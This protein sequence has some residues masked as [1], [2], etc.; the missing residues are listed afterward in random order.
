MSII[1]IAVKRPVTTVMLTLCLVVTGLVSMGRVPLGLM[2]EMNLP[3]AA[4]ITSYGTASPQEVETLVTKPLESSFASLSNMKNIVSYSS[5]GSSTIIVEFAWGTNM[6]LATLEMR[7]RTDLVKGSLPEGA[8]AP[9]VV[10]FDPSSIPLMQIGLDSRYD[11]VTLRQ[12]ADDVVAPRLERLEGVANVTVEGGLEREIQVAV[13]PIQLDSYNLSLQ[14]VTQ[15]LAAANLNLPGGRVADKTRELAVRTLGEYTDIKEIEELMLPGGVRLKDVAVVQDT[16]KEQTSLTRIN[17]R[18]S[19]GLYIQKESGANT[20]FV[21]SRVRAELERIMRDYDGG[22]GY[23]IFWD[24]SD[25]VV[26]ALRNLGEN[27][28]VGALLAVIVLLIFLKN[29]RTTLVIGTAI[30]VGIISAFILLFFGD[31]SLNMMSLGGLALSVG[32]LVDNGI[33]V[34]ENIF[35]HREEGSLADDAARDGAKEVALAII[36]STLTTV[37]V[38]LPIVF[39]EGIAAQLFADLSKTVTFALLASLLVSL[40]LVPMISAQLMR[41][42]TVRQRK[43]GQEDVEGFGRFLAWYRDAIG[44][45][46]GRRWLVVLL[47]GAAF[48]GSLTLIPKIGM[49]FMPAMDAGAI[50]ISVELP[51]GS[52]RE[53]T[54]AIVQHIEAFASQISEVRTISHVVGRGGT[55]GTGGGQNH[56]GQLDLELAPSDERQRTTDQVIEEIREYVGNIPGAKINVRSRDMM[57]MGGAAGAAPIAIS[58]RGQDLDELYFWAE[59]LA[60]ELAAIPG[61]REVRSGVGEGRPELH[62][63]IDRDRAAS[64]GTSVIQVANTIRTAV[65][66]QVATRLRREGSEIDVRVSLPK[67]KPLTPEEL[68]RLLVP[69]AAG[70]HVPLYEVASL[71]EGTGPITITRYGQAREVTVTAQVAG[72][73]LGSVMMDIRKKLDTIGL[74]EHLMVSMRGEAEEMQEAFGDLW[75]AM[76]LATLLVYMILASLFESLIHPLTIM[77]TLPLAA[78][79]VILSLFITG[80]ALSVPALVGAIMLVGIVVNNGIVLVDYI[81]QLRFRGY[82]RQRAIVE[83]SATRVRPVLM[84]TLTTVVAL[85]PLALGIGEGAEMQAPLATVLVGG[86]T[87]STVLTLGFLP[88]FYSIMEDIGRRVGRLWRR[89]TDDEPAPG[90]GQ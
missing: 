76:A 83:G 59:A 15:A 28:A 43:G 82:D 4:V 40:T 29:I 56:L 54:E 80:R 51:W 62:V 58:L 74:P 12:I 44:K 49:E 88:V 33:V 5:L 34:L 66:G 42:K 75:V 69:T 31:I 30:P 17:G 45:L 23:N 86:L 64:L 14:Q 73:D 52:L 13:D 78:I 21:A 26:E 89:V 9:L 48:V 71:G 10:R 38:F 27:I 24:E 22:L 72:R 61:T 70:G 79:G 39:V 19:I 53:E 50:S 1:D 35:R 6:D 11:L 41:G 18:P 67:D 87:T 32:M 63:R 90:V 57:G 84:T 81:N 2:P 77:I 3:Y 46:L 65:D 85:I 60:G 47:V 8:D 68:E 7:E 55:M 16:F 36:A 25:Y 37:A 20:V